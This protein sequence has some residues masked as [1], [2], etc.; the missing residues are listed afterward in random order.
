M[1]RDRERELRK[2]V[3]E[4]HGAGEGIYIVEREGGGVCEK[5]MI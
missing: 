5:P 3:G 4:V 2:G 1:F